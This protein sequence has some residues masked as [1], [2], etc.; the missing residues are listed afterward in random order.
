MM[1]ETILNIQEVSEKQLRAELGNEQAVLR[2]NL[3]VLTLFFIHYSDEKPV[4]RALA[5]AELARKGWVFNRSVGQW[6]LIAKKR[7][8]VRKSVFRHLEW[9]LD[10]V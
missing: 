6:G 4:M 9:K 8:E 3:D 2:S 10:Q 1:A 7:I 5:G